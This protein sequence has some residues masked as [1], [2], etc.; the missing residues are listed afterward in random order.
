MRLAACASLNQ[1]LSRRGLLRLVPA[2]W[3]TPWLA[4]AERAGSSTTRAEARAVAPAGEQSREIT[5]RAD[6]QVHLM[7][8]RL[9]SRGSVG[10][11]VAR[12]E[13]GQGRLSLCFAAGSDPSRAKGFKRI[14]YVHEETSTGEDGAERTSVYGFITET[15]EQTMEEARRAL[16]PAGGEAE[17]YTVLE[18]RG[19][20]GRVEA[21]VFRVETTPGPGWPRWQQAL[22]AISSA[23]PSGQARQTSLE[24]PAGRTTPSFLG[25]V[26]GAMRAG[27]AAGSC[28]YVYNG[29]LYE[30]RWRNR[31]EGALTRMEA[32]IRNSTTGKQTPFELWFDGASRDPL[33]CRFEYQPRG[34]LKLTFVQTEAGTPAGIRKS[35]TE[36]KA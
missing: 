24:F 16:G 25:A 28:P 6:V 12:L 26:H 31:A 14:G 10:G 9:F 30:L 13:R 3:A 35:A 33:P 21:R 20:G 4:L 34:F 36:E 23:S 11:G 5:Y 32:S 27:D 29:R 2:I 15:R 22:E 18:A 17:A 7:G 1:K 19:Q 8:V